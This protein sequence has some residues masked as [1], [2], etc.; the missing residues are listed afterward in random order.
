MKA[1]ARA[2]AAPSSQASA[3]G[4]CTS[5]GSKAHKAPAAASSASTGAPSRVGLKAKSAA[6]PTSGAA[7]A[8][9]TSLRVAVSGLNS[10]PDTSCIATR[11]AAVTASPPSLSGCS[12][13]ATTSATTKGA[14]P[15]CTAGLESSSFI[16][17]GP[18]G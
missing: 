11:N 5:T 1:S 17:R 3:A 9:S 15:A 16:R 14:A 2:A 6:T 10:I 8:R 12:A 13:S 4:R 18:R 7:M